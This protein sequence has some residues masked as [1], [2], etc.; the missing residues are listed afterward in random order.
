MQKT[1]FALATGN[2]I[3]AISVIRVSG[4]DSESVLKKLTLKNFR[5]T[6]YAQILNSIIGNK[7]PINIG[8]KHREKANNA[9]IP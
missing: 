5:F 2:Q 6:S 8:I 1:I 4:K 9:L 3:S 7:N